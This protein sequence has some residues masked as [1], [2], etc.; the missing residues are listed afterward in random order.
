M[1]NDY[2]VGIGIDSVRAMMFNDKLRALIA[3]CEENGISFRDVVRES[4]DSGI[5]THNSPLA[6]FAK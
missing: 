1:G 3:F 2:S 4:L 6:V 5:I